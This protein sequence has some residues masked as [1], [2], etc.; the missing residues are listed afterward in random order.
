MTTFDY[1]ESINRSLLRIA[2]TLEDLT[3][4]TRQKETPSTPSEW[5]EE[6]EDTLSSIEQWMSEIKPF[7][8]EK[9]M[10]WLESLHKKIK[11]GLDGK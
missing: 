4:A 3:E 1:L 9:E 6:D 7:L 5:T 11:N 2:K 10:Q 8:V